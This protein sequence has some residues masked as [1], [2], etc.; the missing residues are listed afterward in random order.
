MPHDDDRPAMTSPI[1]FD[2]ETVL[3]VISGRAS[4]VKSFLL[5][6]RILADVLRSEDKP[7]GKGEL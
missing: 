7:R 4:A 1:V 6:S 3:R 5:G 2:R